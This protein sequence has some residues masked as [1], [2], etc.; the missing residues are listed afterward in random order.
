M[1][2]TQDTISNFIE[3]QFPEFYREQGAEFIEFVKVY[4]EWLETQSKSRDLFSTRDIDLTADQ[5]VEYFRTKYM[6]GIPKDVIGDKRFIQKHIL[7]LY[8]SKGSAEGIKLLFRLLYNEEVK[9]Y[10]PARDI[11][12][13]SDGIWV[14]KQ[15]IEVSDN[16]LVNGKFDQKFITG[17]QSGATAFVDSYQ[18]IFIND[19]VVSLFYLTNITG[20]F[21]VREQ[22]YYDLNLIREAP[23]ILGSAVSIDVV[24]G[25]TNQTYGDVVA[26]NDNSTRTGLSALVTNTYALD[27]GTIAF[28]IENGGFGYSNNAVIT[29]ANGTNSNGTGA[30]FTDYT[31]SNTITYSYIPTLISYAP[32]NGV[33][34]SFNANTA[35]NDV[36]NFISFPSTQFANGDSVTYVRATGNTSNIGLTNNSV[37][38]VRDANTSGIKLSSSYD[39]TV[40]TLTKGTTQNGHSLTGVNNADKVLN[41]DTYGSYLNNANLNTILNDAFPIVDVEIGKISGL[42]GINPG[43]YYNG[44]VIVTIVDPLMTGFSINDPI[45]GGIYGNNAV[46]RGDLVFGDGVPGSVRVIDSGVGYNTENEVVLLYNTRTGGQVQGIVNLGPVGFSKGFWESTKGMLNSDKYIEDN[47]YYQEYSY[48]TQLSRSIDKYLSIIKDVMHPVGNK[49]FGKTNLLVK[50]LTRVSVVDSS[51]TQI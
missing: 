41:E 11:L 30:T 5:F 13:A 1:L 34:Q 17:S 22:V 23:T 49:I 40:I 21:L 39:G 12:R 20:N 31:L 6:A 29:I 51:V 26:T 18:R 33:P 44:N 37:Y 48:E 25:N 42:V 10:Q 19:K 43:T 2:P 4:Y 16:L 14:Q 47:D 9:I 3:K 50:D 45:N 27:S 32:Y 38:Y 36:D 28:S 46:I 8:R 7:D 24:S 15:Y 35:V